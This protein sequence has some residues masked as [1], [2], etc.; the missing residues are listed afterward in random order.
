MMKIVIPVLLALVGFVG[1][2]G[3]AWF[4]KPPPEPE[5][6]VCLNEEGEEVSGEACPKEGE[7]DAHAEE[8]ADEHE[9]A[10]SEFVPLERQFIVPVVSEDR[11]SSMMVLTLSLEVEPGTVES[12]FQREPKLRDALLRAL[13]EH[14]YT[15][16]FTGDFTAEHVMRELRGNLL[17]AARAVV[18]PNVKDVLVADIIKQEQ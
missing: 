15:G 17:K 7:E 13:F 12:V 6:E 16:G 18:G 10:K 2:A 9:E 3:A 4:L 1:G 5:E 14:A 8:A 11:V